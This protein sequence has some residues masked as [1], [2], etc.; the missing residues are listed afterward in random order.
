[1]TSKKKSLS[2]TV[3]HNPLAKFRSN[4]TSGTLREKQNY[5]STLPPLE[6]L[7]QES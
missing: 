5:V 7:N 1:M 4:L 6:N 3:W 2:P